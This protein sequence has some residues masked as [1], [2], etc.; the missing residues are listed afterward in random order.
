VGRIG[1]KPYLGAVATAQSHGIWIKILH[2][3]IPHH[4]YRVN[5]MHKGKDV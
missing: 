2:T 1:V 3:V 5:L 4:I